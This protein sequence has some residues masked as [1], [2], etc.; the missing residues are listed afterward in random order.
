MSE[1]HNNLGDLIDSARQDVL[2]Q[3]AKLEAEL[4]K[5]ATKP[6]GKQILTAVLL[7][8]CA[9]V[10]YFQYPRFAEP[11]AWP[12]PSNHSSAAEGSLLAVVGMIETYR[13]AQG[14]VPEVLSQ[15]ALPEGLTTLIAESPIQYQVHDQTYTLDWPLAQWRATYDSQTE[16]VNVV[17]VDKK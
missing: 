13:M 2:A 9:V 7:A 1:H 15:V 14:K 12:D 8:V 16:T 4:N 6:R 5:S 11:Y 10:L 17:P 3:Q